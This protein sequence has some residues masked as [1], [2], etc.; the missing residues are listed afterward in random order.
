ME[1]GLPIIS[2]I[3]PVYNTEKYLSHCIESVLA[4]T[5]T[6]FELLLIDDG[7]NDNS[8]KIC[9]QYA[10]LDIRIKV[11]HKKN[12]GVSIARNYGLANASGEWCCFIDSDDWVA[13][14]YLKNFATLSQSNE[15]IQL[16]IQGFWQEFEKTGTTKDIELPDRI[17]E[18]NY[19]LVKW[20]EDTPG[21][22][23]GFLWHRLFR[24]DIIIKH[25]I[26]F[27]PHVSFAEDGWFFFQYLQ[28]AQTFA[29]TSKLGYHYRIRE[30][31]L[32]SK[33]SQLSVQQLEKIFRGYIETLYAFNTPVE[34]HQEYLYFVRRY[35]WRLANSWF[36]Q[37]AYKRQ[38]DK[39][40]CFQILCQCIKDYQ[41]NQ[42]K[43]IDISLSILINSI[44]WKESIFKD[45]TIK[46][47][48]LFRKYKQKILSHL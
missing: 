6:D 26:H 15:N 24:M 20:L 43:N 44:S 25:N 4:Q 39:Q 21:V 2:V 13:P 1:N 5:F 27:T 36:V 17:I 46:S 35:A 45:F 28:H 12:E 29:V 40:H 14:Q 10:S 34:Y 48:L 42:L 8:G 33:G 19:E 38:T 18:H 32:T 11:I 31:S 9:D 16:A 22:H 41:L 47:I 3:I 23:N 30:G 7:S 37:R